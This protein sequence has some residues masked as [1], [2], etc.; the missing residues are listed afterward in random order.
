MIKKRRAEQKLRIRRLSVVVAVVVVGVL[1]L[2]G[3]WIA[4][5]LGSGAS[6]GLHN[7]DTA[8][9]VPDH[10]GQPAP[11]FSAVAADGQPYTLTPGDGRAKAI[12]F[13]M[14]FG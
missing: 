4:F 12:V 3:V 8:F 5:R 2:G 11:A 1:I 10:V 13:Y 6:G 9:S 14:G 7:S